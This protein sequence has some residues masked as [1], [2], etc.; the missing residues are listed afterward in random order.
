MFVI[1]AFL[2]Q[3]SLQV[4]W[5]YQAAKRFLLGQMHAH[6][7]LRAHSS[8]EVCVITDMNGELENQSWKIWGSFGLVKN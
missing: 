4:A 7:S 2:A 6:M 1:P 3:A 5:L 8:A